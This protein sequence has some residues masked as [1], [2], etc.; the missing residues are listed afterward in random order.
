VSIVR[1]LPWLVVPAGVTWAW[2][3]ARAQHRMGRPW[4]FLVSDV[5]PGVMLLMAGLLIWRRRPQNRCWWLL[6]AS[7]FAWFVGDFEHSPNQD[8]ALAAFAFGRWYGLFLGWA[9]LAFPT[10]QLQRRHARML[11]AA[12]FAQL[13]VRSLS[14][15]FLH[16]PPDVA[17]YGTKNRFLPISDERWWRL[18]ED[19][20][21]WCYPVTML[22]VLTS[23]ADQWFRSS[24]PG[25][26]MLSPALA[27]AALLSA[28]VAY[29]YAVGWNAALP[30]TAGLRIQYIVWWAYGGVA[31]AFTLGLIRLRRTR[32]AVVD[33]VAE[34]GH[35][36]PPARLGEALARALG[37]GSLTLLPWSTTADSYV[38]DNGRPVELPTDL[39]QRAITRIE[40]RGEP[41]AAL[42][43]D[44]ALLE[45]PGL[46][47]AVVA[48]VRL[49]IDN[50]RLQ[51]EIGNQ[52]AEVAA[53]R[54]RIVAA[55]DAERERIERD[56]HDGAQ[57]RLVAI[58]L[59]LRLAEARLDGDASPAVRALLSRTVDDLGDAITEL[60]DL[61]RGIH[62]AVLT[63][64]GLSAALE[65]LV[66]QSRLPVR[67]EIALTEEPPSA[68]AATAYFAVCEALTNITKHAHAKAVTVRAIGSDAML[69]IE[70]T[71][72]GNGGAD[73]QAGTG[74]RG[75]A[76]RVAS[77]G[78]TLRIESAPARG[79]QLEVEL[80]CASS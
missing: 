38:D 61:A 9:L 71:D 52:L 5:A 3:A 20:F 53:S 42:V 31:L 60:R 56:L 22:L 25:R 39:P 79:T 36:A 63:E 8:V 78:G 58:A 40:R 47:N 10:G 74:L 18:V 51:T 76:D 14:R 59:S 13:A 57:Q 75:I 55:G 65:A 21:A 11:V 46:V 45:D 6:V 30:R 35:D 43:H 70:V 4:T 41:V 32:S 16:V 15:L 24:A 67:L 29:E 19:V 77:V 28:A 72:D 37:D 49:T 50:E 54:S 44:S 23:V 7:G 48:A 1:R 12:L 33:L 64:S 68:I 27:A 26:R 73:A 62:P 34:L 17:G 80:P 2:L 69:R 66:H